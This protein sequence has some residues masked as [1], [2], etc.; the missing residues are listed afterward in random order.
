[1]TNMQPITK[2]DRNGDPSI[3]TVNSIFYTIQGEGPFAGKRAIFV[4]FGGCN[5]QCPLCDTDYTTGNKL[6][7]PYEIIGQLR[8]FPECELIVLTGGEPFLQPLDSLL[9]M[10]MELEYCV[11]IETNGTIGI[12]NTRV[13][14]QN[15]QRDR[16]GDGIHIVCSP[17]AGKVHPSIWEYAG[18]AKYVISDDSRDPDDYLPIKALGHSV[19]ERVARPP[20]G[21]VGEI[22]VQPC[23]A[24]DEETNLKNNYAASLAA[25]KMPYTLQ[26]QIHK[27]FGLE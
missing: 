18:Y 21:W 20:Q 8:R 26:M 12:R 15:A 27:H 3:L 9:Y 4:R 10:L 13:F 11:Q 6:M 25:L 1:M 19:K 22:F 5:L 7:T 2:P 14:E 23:D 24:H 17:K 16:I